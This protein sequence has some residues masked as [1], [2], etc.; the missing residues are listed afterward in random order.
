MPKKAGLEKLIHLEHTSYKGLL[1]PRYLQF[2]LFK[3]HPAGGGE[4]VGEG[5]FMKFYTRSK[6]NLISINIPYS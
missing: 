3:N 2:N 5:E 1:Q 6:N 4:E